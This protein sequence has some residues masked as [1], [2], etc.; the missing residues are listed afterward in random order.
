M[1]HA[2]DGPPGTSL[3]FHWLAVH[4]LPL[5]ETMLPLVYVLLGDQACAVQLPLPPPPPPPPVGVGVGV[6]VGGGGGVTD[7]F[8]ANA[9]V[10]A[11]KSH[12]FYATLLHSLERLPLL[13]GGWH[14]RSRFTDQKV[15]RLMPLLSAKLSTVWKSL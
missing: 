4:W 3:S 12:G 13:V 14:C 15:Y 8:L 1:F 7:V 6:G 2:P 11:V 5:Y 9:T 10:K